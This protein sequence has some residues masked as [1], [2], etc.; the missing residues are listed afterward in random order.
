M[1]C[2]FV[3]FVCFVNVF[4]LLDLDVLLGVL[5]ICVGSFIV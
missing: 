5:E 3:A 2:L 4:E 1:E